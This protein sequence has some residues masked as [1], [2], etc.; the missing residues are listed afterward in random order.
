MRAEKAMDKFAIHIAIV[1]VKSVFAFRSFL[2][3]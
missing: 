2:S 3:I 1:V